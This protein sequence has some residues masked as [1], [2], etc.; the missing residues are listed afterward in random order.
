MPGL[1]RP[2]GVGLA[3]EGELQLV[4]LLHAAAFERVLMRVEDRAA[5][6]VVLVDDREQPLVGGVAD[7]LQAEAG[8]LA[9]EAHELQVH[10]HLVAELGR[11]LGH[12]VQMARRR[13]QRLQVGDRAVVLERVQRGVVP[14]VLEQ[15]LLA[16]RPARRRSPA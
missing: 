12:L 7:Q 6:A 9:A 8:D 15:R 4:D 5:A 16:V 1:S 14:G 11:H 10:R 3:L 2:S 13:E